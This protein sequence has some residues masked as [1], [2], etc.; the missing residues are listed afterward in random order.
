MTNDRFVD[1]TGGSIH[2]MAFPGLGPAAHFSHANGC[3]AG[4][5]APF[6]SHLTGRLNVLA[7]D[8][9][10]H[11]DTCLPVPERLRN[12]AVFVDDM[13]AFIETAMTPPVIGMGHSL[14]AVV[15]YLAAARYP[16]LFSKLVLIDPV[17][18]PRRYLWGMALLWRLGWQG[19]MPLARRARRRKRRIPFFPNRHAD[20][21][22]SPSTAASSPS[23]VPVIFFPWK[24]RKS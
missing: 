23:P 22:V 16:H 13:K 20:W 2:C 12:W 3:C 8:L 5:Y 15:T 17:M 19:R 1:I 7:S 14:G 21:P 11:G 4:T 9:R 24:R 18:L 10:G 6:V